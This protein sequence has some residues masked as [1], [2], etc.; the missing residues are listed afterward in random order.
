MAII[1][2][3]SKNFLCLMI[4]AERYMA[5]LKLVYQ[6]VNKDEGMNALICFKEKW[7]VNILP[8]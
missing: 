8:A 5:D 6:A 1:N 4:K 3:I 7:A 2:P